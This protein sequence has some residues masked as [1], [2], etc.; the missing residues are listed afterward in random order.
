MESLVAGTKLSE[1]S[2]AIVNTGIECSFF[3]PAGIAQ[4]NHPIYF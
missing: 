2:N 4:L 1:R 3:D